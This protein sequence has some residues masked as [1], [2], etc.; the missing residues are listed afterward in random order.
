MAFKFLFIYFEKK[1]LVAWAISSPAM[2]YLVKLF[3]A[4]DLLDFSQKKKERKKKIHYTFLPRKDES[5]LG[6]SM[7][8]TNVS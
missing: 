5:T 7:R 1:L 8:L 4:F 3:N 6:P 2:V